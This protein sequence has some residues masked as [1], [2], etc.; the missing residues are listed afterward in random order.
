MPR[1]KRLATIIIPLAAA[2][3]SS[4]QVDPSTTAT[5]TLDAHK[6]L[7]GLLNKSNWSTLPVTSTPTTTDHIHELEEDVQ[8][9]ASTTPMPDL[10]VLRAP[11]GAFFW[12][13][14]VCAPPGPDT[15]AEDLVRC[16]RAMPI[17]IRLSQCVEYDRK[18][19]WHNVS[20]HCL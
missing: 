19:I 10:K 15:T 20:R 3:P 7:S 12:P 18:G 17:L 2:N 11:N 9:G 6:L 5:S 16:G 13:D 14:E 4:T 8:A 1:T